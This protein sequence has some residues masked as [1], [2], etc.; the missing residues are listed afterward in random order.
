MA[1]R[2]YGCNEVRTTTYTVKSKD[3]RKV[4]IDAPIARDGVIRSYCME[5]AVL[6]SRDYELANLRG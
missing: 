3:L 6:I 2:F 4:D 1:C 5:H